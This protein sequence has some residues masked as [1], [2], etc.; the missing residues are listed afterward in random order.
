MKTIT[1]DLLD[2]LAE[3]AGVSARRR[4]HHNIHESLSDP[5]QRLFVACRL[6]S[7]IRPHAHPDTW[8]FALV[9]RG[10][11]DVLIFD[12][13]GRV[14]ERVAVGPGSAVMGFEIPGN[15]WH[16]W[17]PMED[18]SVFFETKQGPYDAGTAAAFA[19]WAPEEGAPEAQKFTERLRKARVGEMVSQVSDKA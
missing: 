1:A 5:V 18:A 7:Y 9:V 12:E 8:E 15:T 13:K 2:E 11:F 3:R 14:M 4:S 17:V 10:L 19:P 6:G 16:A